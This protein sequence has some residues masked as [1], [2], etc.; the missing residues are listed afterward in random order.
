MTKKEILALMKQ[1]GYTPFKTNKTSIRLNSKFGVKAILRDIG[2]WRGELYF[3]WETFRIISDNFKVSNEAT[4][5]KREKEI[6]Y[7]LQK[8]DPSVHK[9]RLVFIGPNATPKIHFSHEG[10]DGEHPLTKLCD[11]FSNFYGGWKELVKENRPILFK[12]LGEKLETV[13]KQFKTKI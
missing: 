9:E 8:L 7:A 13:Q 5:K 1:R 11:I 6:R 3:E 10:I 2:Y 4:F 12:M